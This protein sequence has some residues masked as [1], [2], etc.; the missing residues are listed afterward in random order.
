MRPN[1]AGDGRAPRAERNSSAPP[2]W[3]HNVAVWV[4]AGLAVVVLVVLGVAVLPGWWATQV[5]SWVQGVPGRGVP[6]GLE[7][8]AVFTLLPLGVG[9]L[10]FRSGLTSKVRIALI[11]IALLLLLP[12]VLTIAIALGSSDARSVLAIAAPGFRGATVVG[13]ALVVLVLAAVLVIRRRSRHTRHTIEE[14][15]ERAKRLAHERAQSQQSGAEP[16]PGVTEPPPGGT[17]PRSSETQQPAPA[18]PPAAPAPP[19]AGRPAP[20]PRSE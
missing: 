15:G 16:Q 20:E 1:R 19:P 13:V 14:A 2:A 6:L 17:E 9:L 5:G 7:I 8:G 4:G 3:L 18:Q 11:V 10:A 12:N